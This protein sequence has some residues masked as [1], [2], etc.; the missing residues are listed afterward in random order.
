MYQLNTGMRIL[1][2]S[3]EVESEYRYAHFVFSQG[4]WVRI[5]AEFRYQNC[6]CFPG[7]WVHVT[8]T[9]MCM[10][11]GKLSP[12]LLPTRS[13]IDPHEHLILWMFHTDAPSPPPPLSLSLSL[14]LSSFTLAHS[15]YSHPKQM[16]R[17]SC[18]VRLYPQLKTYSTFK[19][20][21]Y[22]SH[23]NA[24]ARGRRKF[25]EN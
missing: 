4:S 19:V 21:M 12:Y 9:Y 15:I 17:P 6:V 23:Q 25:N 24:S 10:L 16:S 11:P 14:S 3:K 13:S 20:R 5:P 1:Y 2:A 22:L 8:G 18:K 7:S